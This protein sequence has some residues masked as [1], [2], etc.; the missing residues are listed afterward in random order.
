[1]LRNVLNW[2]SRHKN[3]LPLG[4]VAL[5]CLIVTGTSYQWGTY[6]SGWDTLH[7]EFNLGLYSERV[8]FGAWQEHQGLGAPASQAHAAELPRL[9]FIWLFDL[10]LPQSMV[11]HAMFYFLYFTG[12]IGVYFF[13]KKAWFESKKDNWHAWASALGALFFGLNLGTLQHFYVPLEMFAVHFATLPWLLLVTWKYLKTFNR[14]YLLWFFFIQVLSSPSAH[15]ATLFYM[16]TAVIFL[17]ILVFSILKSWKNKKHAIKPVLLLFLLT[18]AA[19][20]YW[21]IPNLYYILFHSDYVQNAKISRH[22]STEAFWQNQAYGSIANILIFKNFLFNWKDFDFATSKFVTLFDEWEQHLKTIVG[23]PLLFLSAILYLTGMGSTIKNFQKINKEKLAF[24]VLFLVPFFFLNNLNFPSESLFGLLFRFSDTFREALRFP[25]TKFSI[26]FIFAASVYFAEFFS[27]AKNLVVKLAPKQNQLTFK[28]LLVIFGLIILLL[29]NIPA[30]RGNLVSSSMKVEYPDYYFEMFEWFNQQ[31]KED[32][33]VKLPINDFFGWTYHS[34]PIDNPQGYQGAGFIWFGLPQPILDREFDRW[35]DKNEYFYTEISGAMKDKNPEKLH[36]V[37]EKYQVS[38]LLFDKTA[39]DPD[40]NTPDFYAEFTELIKNDKSISLTKTFGPI[41]IFRFSATNN[42]GWLTAESL[43]TTNS[44]TSNLKYDPIY[45]EYGSYAALTDSES[46]ISYPFIDLLKEETDLPISLSE[47]EI[48]VERPTQGK[49]NNIQIPAMGD[50]AKSIPVNIWVKMNPEGSVEFTLKSFLPEITIGGQTIRGDELAP[51][52]SIIVQGLIEKFEDKYIF[53]LNDTF[54][55]FPYTEE[56]LFL[57]SFILP[58]NGSILSLYSAKPEEYYSFLNSPDLNINNCQNGKSEP[59]VLRLE[60]IRSGIKIFAED[61][62]A[63]VSD[64]NFRDIPDRGLLSVYF[65]YLSETKDTSTRICIFED[66][67]TGC[68]NSD[69]DYTFF[70][71]KDSKQARVFETINKPTKFNISYNLDSLGSNKQLTYANAGA[72]F[73]PILFSMFVSKLSLSELLPREIILPLTDNS[74]KISVRQSFS[75]ESEMI[76]LKSLT[77]LYN[78]ANCGSSSGKVGFEVIAGG[79]ILSAENKGVA[80]ETFGF[81]QLNPL[82]EYVLLTTATNRQ[83]RELRLVVSDYKNLILQEIYA[84]NNTVT[85]NIL[86]SNQREGNRIKVEFLGDSFGKYEA[87]NEINNLA[88]APFPLE[89]VA[90]FKLTTNNLTPTSRLNIINAK[91]HFNFLYSAEINNPGQ[92]PGVL[93]LSQSYDPLWLAYDLKNPFHYFSL[94]KI[95]NWANGWLI[96]SGNHKVIIY[97]LPQISIF[98]GLLI[99]LVTSISIII[100]YKKEPKKNIFQKILVG[101]QGR[102]NRQ[103]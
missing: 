27:F 86:L 18:L 83:G 102:N 30:L 53:S 96:P 100:Y 79:H 71:E 70:A 31:K 65:D 39:L 89:W 92:I 42:N 69:P 55:F 62:V 41:E 13:I 59:K 56:N 1:M 8:I 47:T 23:Y 6:L 32:R 29:P 28:Y 57:G 78:A 24:L 90:N 15:T 66:G 36:Q 94:T 88:L 74:E 98:V 58:T 5:V 16:Y 81:N 10:L 76:S 33:I 60:K 37:L 35:V 73:H 103:T 4:I 46:S 3:Q 101:M 9:F 45:A 34:W 97:Y 12:V 63:C 91:R 54:V 25:F 61:R 85:K 64:G 82:Q 44:Q 87:V 20:S 52:K 38:W 19:H 50:Y 22:F 43:A 2:L 49:F 75:Q 77:S 93:Q 99:L 17:F 40:E 68:L 14:K 84:P 95:N 21:I 51:S 11:R 26:I 80:C 72:E 7:P 67:G 48:A